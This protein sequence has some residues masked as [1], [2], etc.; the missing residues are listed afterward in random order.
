MNIDQRKKNCDFI[1]G[2]TKISV[3][4]ICDDAKVNYANLVTYRASAEKTKLIKN[5]IKEEFN[6]LEKYD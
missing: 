4:K 3:K 5:M 6:K 2:F 1:K